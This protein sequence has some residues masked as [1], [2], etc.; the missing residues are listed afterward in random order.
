MGLSRLDNF[1]KSVRGNILY[2]NPND[3][4][5]TDSIENQGNSLTR[6]F[7]TIQRA[8]IES[9]RF[10]YQKGLNN[11]RFGKTT[12]L[13][14][15]GEHTVDNRPG[16]I[17]FGANQY[18][19][20]SGATS[21]DLPPYD[22]TTN[23]DLDSPNNELYKLNSV[24]GGVIVPRGTSIVGLDLRKTKIRPKYVPSPTNA[25]IERSA[26]FR[27]TGGCYFWQF[28]MFDADPNGKCYLDYTANEFVPNFSH[29][30]LT[31]FEYADGV[32]DVSIN[33]DFLTYD[34]GRTDLQMYY[35][36]VGLVYGQSSG[37]A[38]EPDYPSSGIDIQPKIDEYRIVGSTGKS[39]GIS[40]I[41]AGDGVTATTTITVTT[42]SAVD[43]LQVDTPFR[44]EGISAAGYDGQFVVSDKPSDTEAKYIVQ[45]TPLTALP[46][47]AGATLALSSDTVTS[48]SPYIFNVSLRSVYGMCGMFADGDK[49]T[50]FRS[51]VVAQFTG[52]GLQKDNNA[53]VLYNND[54]PQTGTYDDS[55]VISNLHTNSRAVYKPSYSNYHI[56]CSNDATLQIV[57]VF[58]I[59]YAEHFLAES[60]GD[61]SLTNSN[62][63]F[64]AKALISEGYKR[65][66]FDQDNTGYI[67]HIIP[68]KEIPL[69]ESSVEF[70][71]LD[72][73]RTLPSGYSAIGVGSTANLYLYGKSNQ[74]APPE[75]VIEGYRFGARTNDSLKILVSSAGTVTEYSS[76]IVMPGSQDSAE[77]VFTVNQSVTGINSI[78]NRS[79][80]G[81]S[82]TITFDRAHTLINGES[83]RVISD[84]GH[85]PDGLDPNTVYFAITDSN[86][87]ATGVTT[88]TNIQVAKTFNDAVDG[89]PISINN[90]GGLLK[91]VSRVSDK[92]SGDIGHPIQWD[93]DQTQWYVK[94][95]A[96]STENAIFDIITG[97][98]STGLGDATSRSYIKRKSD[99]RNNV[100]TLYRA[101]YVLPKDGGAA[102]P[103]SDGFIVQES[104]TAIGSTNTEIET[105]FGS[106]S[107][108]NDTQQR[109]FSFIADATWDGSAVSVAT[110]LPHHLSVGS[111][112]EIVNVTSTENT[113]G[114]AKAGYNRTYT[115]T[116]ISSSKQFSVGLTTDPGTFTNNT[117]TR[118]TSLPYY[119][120]KRYDNTYY[121][122][123]SEESQKWVSG[124]QDGVYYLT[125]LNASNKPTVSP[126]TEEN[127]SQPIKELYPQTDRDTPNAD[128][129]E[130]R[131][132]VESDLIGDV[133]VNNVKNSITKETLTKYN[134]DQT[135]GVGITEIT[136]VAGTAHTIT[137][138]IDHGLNRVTKLTITDG[139]AGY[140]S[141]SAGDLYNAKLVSIGSSVTGSNATAKLTVDSSGTITAVKVMDGGSAYGI[142]NTLAVAVGVGTTTGYSQAVLTVDK[143]Y[144]NVGDSI[145][146]TGVG[147]ESYAGYNTL[148][149]ITDV[150]I[151]AGNSVTVATSSTITGFTTATG[152]GA[153]NATDSYFYLTGEAIRID[154]LTFNE[155]AGIATVTT[156]NPHGLRV[157]HRVSFTGF[158]TTS[159]LYNGNWV[160][161]DN[162]N[163][164]SF[165]V[166]IGVQTTAPTAYGTGFA[167]REGYAA[168]D[169]V[170]T[171]GA[172][173]LNGRMVPTYAGITTTVSATVASETATSISI[174]NLANLDVNIGDYLVIDDEIVRVK[175]TVASG[176]AAVTVFRGVLGSK[177]GIHTVGSV[178]RTVSMKPVELRRHSII[179]ASGHTF[180]YVGFGPGNYSTAFPDKQNRSLSFEEELLAQ[181]LRRNAGAV[182][183]TGMNDKGVSYNGNKRLSSATGKEE[184]FNTPVATVTGEDIGD[185]SGLNVTDSTEINV[186]RSIKVEGGADSKVASE[187]N[188]PIIVNNKLTSNSSKGIEAQS[189]YVQG[190]QTVS[191]KHTLSGSK[192]SLSGNPGD[193]SYFADPADGG[194]VGWIYTSNNEWRKFGSISLST[195]SEI[196]VFDQVGIA[197]TTPGINAFQ[198]G[199]GT[200]I[201]AIDADGVGIGTTANSYGL[202]S[203]KDVRLDKKLY[204]SDGN[205]G[206]AGD[207]LKSTGA[208]VTWATLGSIAQWSRTSGDD[209]IYNTD[210]DLVGI[211]TSSPRYVAEIGNVGASGTTFHV[212]GD[213]RFVGLV[214]AADVT[215][216]GALTAVGTYEISNTTSG[217]IHATSV[218]VAT[219][220]PL[221]SV[222]V[223]SAGTNVVVV[224]SGGKV[225]VG[226]TNPTIDGLDVQAHT[227]LQSYSEQ[228]SAL[229]ISSNN[230]EI[231]LSKSQ[232]FTLSLSDAV[233]DFTLINIPTESTSF[234][235]KITQ[236]STGSRNVGIDTFK[237]GAGTTFPVYWPSGVVPIV[238]TTADKTDIYSFKIFD[239]SN[240]STVGMYGIVGGQNFS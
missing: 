17:P 215:V 44:I 170:I 179:R 4:D 124:E 154:T 207:V 77:K 206:S 107:L 18:Y 165:A 115:V 142:G 96:A 128:P 156:I 202:R 218:G 5:A 16:Y 133:V 123:S 49:A 194:Y 157:D 3:L 50:G 106:G 226:T 79:D 228:V 100:D 175:T 166:N 21:N 29:H 88:N 56:R 145:R 94:V 48:S 71:S 129:D 236:D 219:D 211:G 65:N 186:S 147:S 103:P 73:L 86:S 84:N 205:A 7:K 161:T 182:F 39:V 184:I 240:I 11:D 137:T 27:V 34:A 203:N 87:N 122:Y 233:T 235:L 119:K 60:G 13:L 135:I 36:K 89:E 222:Q 43:G 221:Q 143:I 126:F 116:G 183:Y 51:M 232:T 80:G 197:T 42:S 22:L 238:T 180:E 85:L 23:F 140:G 54:T 2:V 105:Y 213:S 132:F 234:T 200:S 67:T 81:N 162:I 75:N 149:R 15:P 24:Y 217:T 127:F 212:N 118:N 153:T 58:A 52:I 35:E 176:A 189:Y 188:G 239:G 76:R 131:C 90:K 40:S 178:A 185:L 72:V 104:N 95:A 204:G 150:P 32:N 168:N 172:E 164:N 111:E 14:Y 231:D 47:V 141:G 125:L 192:P 41:K 210:Q 101:R 144:D 28:S 120:R 163:L 139:G 74:E 167:L 30:K 83:V 208:G 19:E 174:T 1:L 102:R 25:N 173:S 134:R 92:N 152:I 214:T 78:G 12:I 57:S 229:T 82:D 69:T 187:F 190:D 6:P 33:D 230:V 113:A 91:V 224:T 227:R 138:N 53:F 98:G 110:E 216:G 146:I 220:S 117:D 159:T 70:E 114:T 55:T 223:G 181:S 177:A 59:G 66:A 136:S 31:C 225:G 130:T 63:N 46:S 38:I 160:V 171:E 68:P 99:N 196:A 198:V 8:L 10:S 9:S 37:R 108:A 148:Y 26:L 64:G 201:V 61:Q 121:V 199:G 20:R 158:T 112:V 237:I 151:G 97:I 191:R 193:I 209:G 169:G 109:N 45:N 195:D 93:G 155:N 62:S